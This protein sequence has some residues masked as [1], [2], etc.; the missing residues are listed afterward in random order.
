M[1]IGIV[2]VDKNYGIGRTNKET[3]K[4]ELL[5][6]LKKDMRFFQDLT[7][8]AGFVVFGETTYLSL[9]TRPLKDRVNIVLCPE[10]HEY[11]D[12]ICFHDFN[13]LLTFVQTVAKRFDVCICGGGMLYRSML[14]YYDKVFVTKVDADGDAEVFFPNLD[15]RTDFQITNE[16]ETFEENGLSYKF[17]TYEKIKDTV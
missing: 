14:P 9:P 3:D 5:F 12:C 6:K 7:T 15:E 8:G 1:I 2:A 17:V 13:K 10:G 11:E 4:G 16:S